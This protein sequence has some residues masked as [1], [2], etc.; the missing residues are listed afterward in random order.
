VIRNANK[1]TLTYHYAIR[2]EKIKMHDSPSLGTVETVLL[3]WE[4][5]LAHAVG[6]HLALLSKVPYNAT[7][8]L[9]AIDLSTDTLAT[10]R[11]TIRK[12]VVCNNKKEK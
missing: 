12:F 2:L 11:P 8:I 10:T 9:V 4:C 5:K 6:K 1:I 3:L 7:I